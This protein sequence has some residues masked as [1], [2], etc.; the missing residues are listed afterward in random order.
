MERRRNLN[1][2]TSTSQPLACCCPYRTSYGL[3]AQRDDEESKEMDGICILRIPLLQA[4]QRSVCELH[5][6]ALV[7]PRAESEWAMSMKKGTHAPAAQLVD[8]IQTFLLAFDSRLLA[9]IHIHDSALHLQTRLPGPP[10]SRRPRSA[11]VSVV[12][13][14]HLDGCMP[15]LHD[16]R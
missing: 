4:L 5:S 1:L 10:H 3:I 7:T 12:P 9:A 8:A 2:A 11:F 15:S 14:D 16:C 6:I 13:A